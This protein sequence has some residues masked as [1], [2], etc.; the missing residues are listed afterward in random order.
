M[1]KLNAS[2]SKKLTMLCSVAYFVSYLTRLNFAAVIAAITQDGVIEKTTAGAVTTIG[3]ITYGVGQLVS[4]W[5]GDRINPKKLMFIG[6]ITTSSMNFLI[7]FCSTGLLMCVVWGINGFAQSLMW[8]PMVKI[9]KTALDGDRYN[10]SCVAVNWG[11]TLATISIYLISPVIIS[12]SS[13]RVVFFITSAAAAVMS[14][15]WYFKITA[16]EKTTGLS[17]PTHGKAKEKSQRAYNL[18]SSLLIIIMFAIFLQGCL[19]DGVTTWVPTYVSEVFSLGSEKS[20]LSGVA[21]PIFS[22]ISIQLTSAFFY[23]M[24]RDAFKCSIILFSVAALCAILLTVLPTA[25]VFVTIILSALIVACMHGINLI[26]V[27]FIP[28]IYADEN[29]V[30]SLSGTLNFMTYVGSAAST[31]GFALVSSSSGWSATVFIWFVIA[32]LGALSCFGAKIKNQSKR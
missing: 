23:K 32:A 4:G 11:G 22:L 3:F 1:P 30:A 20:I 29:N 18:S 21:V 9:M 15:L 31:Y 13:W 12:F 17:Y 25:S 24:K 28:A 10:K 14:A 6:F 26:L 27:C 2:Q 7:P 19:R 5:L 16:I 8:P